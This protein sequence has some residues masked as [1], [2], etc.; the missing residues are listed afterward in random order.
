MIKIK[1]EPKMKTSQQINNQARSEEKITDLRSRLLDITKNFDYKLTKQA[2]TKLTKDITGASRLVKLQNIE[3]E[4]IEG[5]RNIQTKGKRIS[6]QMVSSY[7]KEN[8]ETE[9]QA[10]SRIQQTFRH[11]VHFKMV[12]KTDIKSAMNGAVRQIKIQV[13]SLGATANDN[14]PLILRNAFNA[15]VRESKLKVAPDDKFYTKIGVKVSKNG[16]DQEHGID[17]GIFKVEE[18]NDWTE[19]TREQMQKILQSEATIS[20]KNSIFT[21]SFFTPPAGGRYVFDPEDTE[22][23]HVIS[24]KTVKC[25]KKR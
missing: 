25:I 3:N 17:T 7:K 21:F 11:R 13:G 15:A 10:A 8:G 18:L 20:L 16:D 4:Y 6:L 9:K 12:N 19:S 22:L 2:Y 14:I 23:N 24:R 1:K 5:L